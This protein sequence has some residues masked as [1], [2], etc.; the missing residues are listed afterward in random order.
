MLPWCH[1]S[2]FVTK[3]NRKTCLDSSKTWHK[4]PR[5][6][7]DQWFESESKCTCKLFF[8]FFFKFWG[9]FDLFTIDRL[10]N[11]SRKHMVLILAYFIFASIWNGVKSESKAKRMPYVNS[12]KACLLLPFGLWLNM[13]F[14]KLGFSNI[15]AMTLVRDENMLA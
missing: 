12:E 11:V 6:R 4:N 13:L 8:F 2:S 5:W 10:S 7:E 3:F 9:Y 14:K 15:E 1:K